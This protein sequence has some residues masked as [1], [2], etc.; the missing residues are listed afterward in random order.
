ML[1]HMVED[2]DTMPTLS[3]SVQELGK[4]AGKI[5]GPIPSN[6]GRT[7]HCSRPMRLVT[8]RV[9]ISVSTARGRG[10]DQACRSEL[11][12][13]IARRLR[14]KFARWREQMYEDYK[15][16]CETVTLPAISQSDDDHGTSLGL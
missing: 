3:G 5:R 14:P 12:G 13:I 2:E 8:R 11:Q 10:G 6:T 16:L 1:L 9:L 15:R 7:S 4:D